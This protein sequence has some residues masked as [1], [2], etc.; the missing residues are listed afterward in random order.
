MNLKY[1]TLDQLLDSVTDDLSVYESEGMIDRSQLIKVV[2]KVNKDLGLK[3]NKDYEGVIDVENYKA[4]LPS[5]FYMA[6]HIL[7]CG[8]CTWTEITTEQ[9]VVAIDRSNCGEPVNYCC[10]QSCNQKMDCPPYIVVDKKTCREYSINRVAVLDLKKS[11]HR[12]LCSDSPNWRSSCNWNGYIDNGDIV[13]NFRDGKLYLNYI[14]HLEDEDG[15]LLVLSHDLIDEY[16]E[17]A[18]KERIFENI[19]LNGEEGVQNKLQYLAMKK[20]EARILALGITNMPEYSE[21]ES[22]HKYY[23]KRSHDRYDRIIG[24]GTVI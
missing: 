9:E 1:R 16:Y 18:L 11:S 17:Y 3:I 24:S 13:T 5:N 12:D 10:D 22:I 19:W 6:N 21:L 20:R 15:N 7:V 2:Q 14:G 23:R 8:R 4:K